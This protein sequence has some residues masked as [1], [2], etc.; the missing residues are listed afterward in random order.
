MYAV[1]FDKGK[2]VKNLKYLFRNSANERVCTGT[3]LAVKSSG[4]AAKYVLPTLL[5][6]AMFPAKDVLAISGGPDEYIETDANYG[7]HGNV[8]ETG[9]YGNVDAPNGNTVFIGGEVPG[10]VYGGWTDT[11][12]VGKIR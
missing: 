7:G 11:G 2:W 3:G 4:C 10:K 9:D 12:S 5:C 8:P 6:L 1:F